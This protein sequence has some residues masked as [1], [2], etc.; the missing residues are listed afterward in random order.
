MVLKQVILS[1]TEKEL[2]LIKSN[3][4]KLIEDLSK[5]SEALESKA[6]ILFSLFVLIIGSSLSCIIDKY[7]TLGI[8]NLIIHETVIALITSVLALTRL[9]K[10][11]NLKNHKMIGTKPEFHINYE[12]YENEDKMKEILKDTIVTYQSVIDNNIEVHQEKVNNM[13]KSLDILM[14]GIFF[15]IAYALLYFLFRFLFSQ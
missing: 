5:S 2:E 4:E 15:S 14:S 9:Y 11:L 8:D 6:N 3:S 13:Q 10:V 7:K 12:G 1:F